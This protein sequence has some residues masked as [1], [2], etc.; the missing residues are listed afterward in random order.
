L[1]L[2]IAQPFAVHMAV[3]FWTVQVSPHCRQLLVV[4][5]GVSQPLNAF[6]SQSA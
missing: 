1:Q 5:S 6:P 3:P 2:A 4:P